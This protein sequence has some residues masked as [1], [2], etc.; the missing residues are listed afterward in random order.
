MRVTF[1]NLFTCISE[2]GLLSPYEQSFCQFFGPRIVDEQLARVVAPSLLYFHFADSRLIYSQLRDAWRRATLFDPGNDVVA[3]R[4]NTNR[5]R[6]FL[7]TMA[8]LVSAAAISGIVPTVMG[9]CFPRT[10]FGFGGALLVGICGGFWLPSIATVIK[11][12]VIHTQP[13]QD[14]ELDPQDQFDGNPPVISIIV[15]FFCWC[16]FAFMQ[17][18]ARTDEQAFYLGVV[19]IVVLWVRLFAAPVL[20]GMILGIAVVSSKRSGAFDWLIRS[21]PSALTAHIRLL[22]Q[23]P[24]QPPS[25]DKGEIHAEGPTSFRFDGT[26]HSFSEI[27]QDFSKSL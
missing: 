20:R 8:S 25:D 12:L 10:P 17:S 18:M 2:E 22:A 9:E 4:P 13:S 7:S 21:K 6:R 24:S 3:S 26:Q 27:C 15:L 16:G 5:T 1:R 14:S 19:G 23:Q 11:G